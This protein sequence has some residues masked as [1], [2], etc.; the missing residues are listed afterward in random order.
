MQSPNSQVASALVVFSHCSQL[1]CRLTRD[2]YLG[3]PNYT[4]TD[5]NLGNALES[6]DDLLGA[7]VAYGEAIRLDTIY[8]Y[9]HR[10]MGS[11]R[12]S[13]GIWSGPSVT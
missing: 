6:S 9:A 13:Q 5:Y 7:I 12:E 11:P 2:A 3:D 1:N 8:D 10:G 4:S